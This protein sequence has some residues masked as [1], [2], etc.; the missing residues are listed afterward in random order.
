MFENLKKFM[1]WLMAP[2]RRATERRA[3]WNWID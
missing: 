3:G 1:R 2:P